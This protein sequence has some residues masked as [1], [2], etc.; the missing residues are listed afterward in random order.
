MISMLF[1]FDQQFPLVTDFI[2]MLT[3]TI[4]EIRKMKIHL[5]IR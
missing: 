1:L 5:L 3:V 2:V 4:M